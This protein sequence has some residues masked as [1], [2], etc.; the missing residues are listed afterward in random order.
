MNMDKK[1]LV[2]GAVMGLLAIVLGAFGSHA[3]KESLTPESLSSF[4]TGVRYQMY[5]AL[6]LLAIGSTGLLTSKQKKVILVLVLVGMLLFSFSI[7]LLSTKALHG[8]DFGA[9]GLITP[10]GG[11]VLMSAWVVFIIQVLRYK[12]H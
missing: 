8:V 2:S 1:V 3:L 10:I 11:L 12:K 6:M 9:I 5:H 7:Y 4:E